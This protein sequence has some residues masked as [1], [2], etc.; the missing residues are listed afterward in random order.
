ML[1]GAERISRPKRRR[2]LLAGAAVTALLVAVPV[3]F[4][5]V[6]RASYWPAPGAEMVG[7]EPAG[8]AVPEVRTLFSALK[9]KPPGETRVVCQGSV[10]KYPAKKI[11]KAR[12][13]LTGKA[14][15]KKVSRLKR[16]FDRKARKNESFKL[17]SASLKNARAQG[18]EMR[19]S[20]PRIAVS[21]KE[22]K[23]LKKFNLKLV[24]NCKFDQIQEAVTKSGNNDR[25]V[26]MPGTYTE[27]KSRAA[28]TNDPSCDQYEIGNDEGS[29]TAVSY[30][31]QLNC[32]NDQNL[33][34][35]LGRKL[36]PG[37][38]P[39]P[40]FERRGIP[41]VGACIRCNLQIE[42]SGVSPD[43]VVVD[44]GRVESGNGGPEGAVKDV[45]F[46]ADRADGFVLRNVTA[47]HAAEH[48]VYVIESDGWVLE[49]FKA[50]Y[51]EEYGV[52]TFVGDHG[53]I[54][55][56]DAA[57]S[58]DS[59][60]YPGAAADTGEQT[61]EATQRYNTEVTRCD[62]HHSA[63]GYSGT[64][65]N[66]VW[67]HENELYDNALGLTTDVFTAPGHPGF[68]QDS[69]L[70]ENNNF[71]SNNFNP[72]L[73]G[74]EVDP[75][76]P[77]PVGVGMWIAGG[78]NNT[79]R[80]NHFYDNWRRGVMLFAVPNALVCPDGET[81]A[82]PGCRPAEQ[83]TSFRNRFHGNSM[84]RRPDGTPDPNGADFFWDRFVGNTNNCWFNNTGPDGT[85]GSLVNEA[86]V[87]PLP[88]DCG[89]TSI[90]DGSAPAQESEL[91]DCFVALSGGPTG[92]CTWYATPPEP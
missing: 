35:V 29:S 5:H 80:N 1:P 28:P 53:V 10:P 50:F 76:V 12:L 64:A 61:V 32:P 34:A 25:V 74:S 63:S 90:G 58:G 30:N 42:G 43:D 62:M 23:A 91:L 38:D 46:R 73:P 82:T 67:I 4:G 13:E 31:Y 2:G 36:G 79:V 18:Y 49:H 22:S 11:K 6:E 69:D 45:V 55:D 77:V 3:A 54:R 24:R 72:Y 92:T 85:A 20:Q 88:S 7:G 44:A 21:K 52:L 16:K 39:P 26:I 51:N 84:G 81:V 65:A 87:L 70:I 78:N 57:G 60:L 17:L 37:T 47:R 86:G 59:A 33:V 89:P 15:D 66:A 56:C 27:P 19:P 75:T 40:Q 8:G 48:G 9:T 83:S 14:E 68:P 71:R 41:N